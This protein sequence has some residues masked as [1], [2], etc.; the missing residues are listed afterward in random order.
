MM[1]KGYAM[2]V[3]DCKDKATPSKLAPVEKS[4]T[5]AKSN[6]ELAHLLKQTLRIDG[7]RN[8]KFGHKEQTI[9][10]IGNMDLLK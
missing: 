8:R 3:I 9:I 5:S 4:K 7:A 1:T 10:A 6:Q 2:E